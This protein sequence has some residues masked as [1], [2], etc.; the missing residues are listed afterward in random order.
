MR[1]S[2]I[3]RVGESLDYAHEYATHSIR[4]NILGLE[5][6]QR[7]QLSSKSFVYFL[8]YFVWMSTAKFCTFTAEQQGTAPHFDP[9]VEAVLRSHGVHDEI[10][11]NFRRNNV[12]SQAVF[13]A[14]DSS[15]EGLRSMT[16]YAFGID[17]SS[18]GGFVHKREMA[19]VI[20]SWKESQIQS[21]TKTK[22]DSVARAHGGS[23]SSRLSK[24]DMANGFRSFTFQLSVTSKCSKKRSNREGFE[25]KNWLR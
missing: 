2:L 7:L 23:R 19:K 13:V 25:Q 6:S 5:Q 14:L 1:E 18:E 8:E 21:E 15:E 3:N 12:L 9:S 11:M 22:V 20:A 17:L 16:K 24:T 10:I 4:R